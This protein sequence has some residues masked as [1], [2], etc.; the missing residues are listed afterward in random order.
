ML[1]AAFADVNS[2]SAEVMFRSMNGGIFSQ[3]VS[4]WYNSLQAVG[5]LRPAP[6][7]PSIFSGPSVSAELVNMVHVD[8]S[9]A[10][11]R[12]RADQG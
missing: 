3:K 11:I 4:L 2:W 7:Q 5:I 12:C 9:H 1:I 8:L 6:R 10:G